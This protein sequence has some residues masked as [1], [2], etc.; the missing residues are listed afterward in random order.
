MEY[1]FNGLYTTFVVGGTAAVRRPTYYDREVTGLTLG[2]PI[3]CC[4]TTLTTLSSFFTPLRI[5]FIQNR[6]FYK[7]KEGR[8]NEKS[9]HNTRYTKI[10]ILKMKN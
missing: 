8:S 4:I 3:L 2:L 6:K 7:K 5:F 1:W 10:Y 9:T